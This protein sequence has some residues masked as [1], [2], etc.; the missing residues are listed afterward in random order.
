M[1]RILQH[2]AD[3]MVFSDAVSDERLSPR[4][5][6]NQR[7]HFSAPDR[8]ANELRQA[9]PVNRAEIRGASRRMSA[10]YPTTKMEPRT[11][12]AP[13]GRVGARRLS[14]ISVLDRDEYRCET[15]RILSQK[16]GSFCYNSRQAA[17]IQPLTNRV[18]SRV[19]G[20][21]MG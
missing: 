6:D 7:G 2:R 10:N 4:C 15:R 5:G 19:Y 12:R 14:I 16:V 11:Q 1:I 17:P 8:T 9:A 20:N 18:I 21:G 3:M 13:P